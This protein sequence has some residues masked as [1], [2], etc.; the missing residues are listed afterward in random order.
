MGI[1]DYS[2][3]EELQRKDK[4]NIRLIRENRDLMDLLQTAKQKI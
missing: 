1:Y 4:D 2:Y 3:D